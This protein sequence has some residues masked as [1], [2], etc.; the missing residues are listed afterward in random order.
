MKSNLLFYTFRYERALLLMLGLWILLLFTHGSFAHSTLL[1][2]ALLIILAAILTVMVT[3]IFSVVKH[4]DILADKL[5]EPYGTL[6][7]TLSVISIE[8][9]MIIM[10]MLFNTA[11]PQL[12][13]DTM[14]S[15]VMISLNG[16]AG[17]SLF[18][19]GLKHKVQH[20]NLHGANAYL[21]ALIPLTLICLVL[22]NF[23][24]T[25][26]LA[27]FSALD[28]IVIIVVCILLYAVFLTMQTMTHTSFFQHESY[29]E[30]QVIAGS[31]HAA[32]RCGYHVVMLLIGIVLMMLL[33]KQLSTYLDLTIVQLGWPHALVGLIIALIVLM[34]EGYSSVK[35]AG[36]NELQRSV[37]LCMGSAL[38]TICLTVPSV[39][40]ICLIFNH[41]I[42]LGL[43]KVNA[44]LLVLTMLVSLTTYSSRQ[45]SFFNGAVHLSLFVIY[46]LVYL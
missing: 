7:L 26:T 31:D 9:A 36:K 43:D 24:V 37:N 32:T 44:L 23:T 20:Y 45:T 12:A 1:L 4:A 46:F 22:P 3:G 11:E 14:Y 16:F 21:A 27:A 41:T 6:I 30:E 42:I 40:I 33:S 38:A 34:P 28:S 10:L 17:L 18:W 5:G 13:R 25:G 39:L 8:V 35:A 2:W 19:G 15:V 29:E